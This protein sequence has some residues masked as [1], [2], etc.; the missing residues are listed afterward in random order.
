MLQMLDRCCQWLL[1]WLWR[2]VFSPIAR[3][4]GGLVDFVG[5]PADCTREFFRASRSNVECDRQL[6]SD[7]HSGSSGTFRWPVDALG[8]SLTSHEEK[9]TSG[10]IFGPAQRPR[11]VRNPLHLPGRNTFTWRIFGPSSEI[12]KLSWCHLTNLI[13]FFNYLDLEHRYLRVLQSF[14]SVVVIQFE[15]CIDMTN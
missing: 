2:F 9:P 13:F 5:G 15:I 6:S 8:R 4:H 3:V 1:S 11:D 7:E 12:I 14:E 10:L